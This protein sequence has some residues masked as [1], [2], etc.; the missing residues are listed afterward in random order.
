MTYFFFHNIQVIC[1]IFMFRML[2][3]IYI[4][5][6]HVYNDRSITDAMIV[7][8][9]E[10]AD[11]TEQAN[12]SNA[13]SLNDGFDFDNQVTMK[14][15]KLVQFRGHGLTIK[16]DFRFQRLE[17]KKT[18]VCTFVSRTKRGN[19]CGFAAMLADSK[20]STLLLTPT[21][22]VTKRA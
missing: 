15:S 16:N 4:S 7:I 22:G 8:W 9:Y 5:V 14:L 21:K 3:S 6:L 11:P 10:N 13:S 1:F 19:F 20:V 12:L 18:L 2:A 17:R